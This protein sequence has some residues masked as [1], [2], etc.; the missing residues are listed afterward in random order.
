[1]HAYKNPFLLTLVFLLSISVKTNAEQSF[2]AE[3]PDSV[4]KEFN[5]IPGRFNKA[6]E[7]ENGGEWNVNLSI[8]EI[9]AG[10]QVPLILALHWAGEGTTYLEFSECLAFPALE[11]LDAIIVTP[12]IGGGDWTAF[13][14]E[15]K[16]L[17]LLE[18]IIE[19]WPVDREKIIVT[20]YSNGGIGSW[21]YSMNNPALFKA[22]IP[23]AGYYE[24]RTSSV[25]QYMIHGRNDEL[26]DIS[27]I[28]K[29]VQN[30]TK[31]GA[32]ITFKELKGYSHFAA[33]G[34]VNEL[35]KMASKMQKE[36]F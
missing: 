31:L 30:S 11:F 1:M 28:R 4:I 23:I 21:V 2:N 29:A 24:P 12:Q 25:H 13:P 26:F 6:F 20:G 22:S 8:P 27:L 18:Q 10:E 5:L 16:V 17:T 3:I 9:S 14:N 33:C 32:K 35:K 7:L 19:F 15:K 36:L 34:Y